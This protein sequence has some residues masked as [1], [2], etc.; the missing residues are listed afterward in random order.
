[1]AV[2]TGYKDWVSLNFS[3]ILNQIF[4]P[5]FSQYKLRTG[6]YWWTQ[7]DFIEEKTFKRERI[8]YQNFVFQSYT[9][10]VA[11]MAFSNFVN[12]NLAGH[13]WMKFDVYIFD[14]T[15]S[16]KF[17]QGSDLQSFSLDSGCRLCEK[18]ASKKVKK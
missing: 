18:G 7:C 6:F 8:F 11:W 1:M 9:N 15:R 14:P 5:Y 2:V 3:W 12:S 13:L 10:N 17:R 4:S 16:I